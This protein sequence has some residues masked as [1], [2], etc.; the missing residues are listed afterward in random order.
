M[1]KAAKGLVRMVVTIATICNSR[2]F[3]VMG[4]LQTRGVAG[5]GAGEGSSQW[6]TALGRVRLQTMVV[7]LETELVLSQEHALVSF[8]W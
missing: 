2:L 6:E 1:T 8:R 7:L 4:G 5:V 3:G